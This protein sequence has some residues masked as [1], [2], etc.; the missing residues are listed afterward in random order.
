MTE[1]SVLRMLL[2][3]GYLKRRASMR[4]RA[5]LC[6]Q[7]N[8]A[9]RLKHLPGARLSRLTTDCSSVGASRQRHCM[10]TRQ[11]KEA[12]LVVLRLQH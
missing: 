9:H 2:Q 1:L 12:A 6:M 7:T 8:V 4:G 3:L 5:E 10:L 11:D